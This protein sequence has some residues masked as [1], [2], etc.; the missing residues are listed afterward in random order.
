MPQPHGFALLELVFGMAIGLLV[1]VA[2]LGSLAAMQHSSKQVHDHLQLQHTSDSIFQTIADQVGH[3]GAT[4]L[5]MVPEHPALVRMDTGNQHIP[6]IH[7]TRGGNGADAFTTSHHLKV[8]VRNCLG[9]LQ[10]MPPSPQTTGSR[11]YHRGSRLLCHANGIAVPLTLAYNVRDFQVRYV[12]QTPSGTDMQWQLRTADTVV[13][14][15][16]IAAVSVCLQLVGHLPSPKRQAHTTPL[17]DCNARPMALEN[18]GRAHW[19]R[20]R[21]FA[22]QNHM[23]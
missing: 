20:T 4:H 15:N 9:Q 8:G 1:V 12:E 23:P 19:V 21:V 17:R 3:A 6:R 16:R 10:K 7:G 2:A 22:V 5:R 14:W 18:D 11:F 13:H